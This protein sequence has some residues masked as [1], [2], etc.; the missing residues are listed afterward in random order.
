MYLKRSGST[1]NFQVMELQDEVVLYRHAGGDTDR[2]EM[3]ARDGFGFI[4]ISSYAEY[5]QHFPNS[6]SNY[7]IKRVDKKLVLQQS[8]KTFSFF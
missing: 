2:L 6:Q 4:S 5:L 7:Y 1:S 3:V 8:H